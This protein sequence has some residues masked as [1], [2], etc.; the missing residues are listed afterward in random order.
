MDPFRVIICICM[1]T[2]EQ[3]RQVKV[4]VPPFVKDVH[5]LRGTMEGTV[6]A[7][8]ATPYDSGQDEGGIWENVSD[9]CATGTLITDILSEALGLSQDDRTATNLAFWLHDSGKKTER[10]WQIA[11]E[12]GLPMDEDG[13][14]RMDSRDK[15]E[16]KKQALDVVERMEEWENAEAG[17][18]PHISR[19]M[20]ANIPSSHRNATIAEKIMWF[21]DACLTGTII[22]PIR[23]RF[24]DLES[25]SRNGERNR[26]FSEGF[27]QQYNG[28]TL[29]EVQRDLGDKYAQEF[30][31]QLGISPS[32][33]FSWLEQRIQERMAD[34]QLPEF[35]L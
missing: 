35:L 19:L 28:K 12:E 15:S 25:D 3:L 18:S 9:H 33:I 20:K 11:I 1:L 8:D 7:R 23:Q 13:T 10:M 34:Q 14:E 26:A 16:A 27:R 2:P 29:Y 22:K 21:A 6:S 30:A 4:S 31:Q 5:I 17:V 24:D 32:E